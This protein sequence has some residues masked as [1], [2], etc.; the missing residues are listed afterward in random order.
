MKKQKVLI[1][2][3]AS[4][5][6]K[7]I[8]EKFLTEGAQVCI[9]DINQQA[10]EEFQKQQPDL[11]ALSADLSKLDHLTEAF[12]KAIELLNGE[13]DVLVNN[14]GISGPTKAMHELD[15]AEWQSVIQINL[16]STFVLTQLAVPYLK[17]SGN[18][19]I[20]NMSSA[21]GRFGYPNRI[22]YSTTKWGLVGFTKTL[23]MELGAFNIRANAIAPGAVEGPRFKG[24][25]VQRAKVSGRSVEEET[26]DALA[27]QSLKYMVKPEHIADLAYFLA[28]ESGRSI[29]GQLIPMDGDTQYVG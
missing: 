3:G 28:S 5:I 18:A 26:M 11:I 29:S 20:I 17:T 14:T 21:A 23:A 25:L 1:S 4:G 7:A 15:F 8:A 2:A 16:N 19:A 24:V 13:L 6:G 12:N 27:V 9:L 10:L 22:A